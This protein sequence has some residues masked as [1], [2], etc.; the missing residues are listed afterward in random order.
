MS[1]KNL[2][3]GLRAVV[4]RDIADAPRQHRL[5]TPECPP[6]TRFTPGA[7]WTTAE[8]THLA[9]CPYC[10]KVLALTDEALRHQLQA[11]HRA[12]VKEIQGRPGLTESPKLSTP[13]VEQPA[14]APEQRRGLPSRAARGPQRLDDI[15]TDWETISQSHRGRED[16]AAAAR[17]VLLERYR[18]AVYRYLLSAVRDPS[19]AEDL[20]QEFALRFIQGRFRGADPSQGRFRNYVKT[21]LFH[22]VNDWRKRVGKGLWPVRLDSDEV[23]P[24]PDEKA[25][26]EQ[27]FRDSWRQELLARAWKA[28]E[29]EQQS[30]QPYYDVLR[31]R[32]DHPDMPSGQ[33]AEQLSAR[34]ARPFTAAGVRKLL[35][36]AR[37]RFADLLLEETGQALEGVRTHLEEELAELN[38]LKYCASALQRRGG[39]APERRDQPE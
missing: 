3:A 28:L 31:F 25:A 11:A 33:M 2:W 12:E 39:Q 15:P 37:E 4:A 19:V 22:L 23:V 29:G 21:A 1:E 34:L 6:L 26:A 13:T 27:A 8:Q 35:Q 20:T 16:E 10:Q 18:G 7:T 38:L 30:S 36:R 5:R 14:P 32:V 24:A 17:E 9:N